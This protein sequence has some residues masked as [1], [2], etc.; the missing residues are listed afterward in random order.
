MSSWTFLLLELTSTLFL[1][2]FPS[3]DILV[4]TCAICKNQIMDL[5]APNVSLPLASR[6]WARSGR[7][8]PELTHFPFSRPRSRSYRHRV[9][10]QPGVGNKRGVHRRLGSV[11]RESVVPVLRESAREGGRRDDLVAREDREPQIHSLSSTGALWSGQGLLRWLVFLLLF[12]SLRPNGSSNSR[13]LVAFLTRYY[14]PLRFPPS[15]PQHAFHFHCIS[16]WLKTRQGWCLPSLH[17]LSTPP[18]P[19]LPLVSN[20]FPSAS[21]LA[22]LLT[23][24][25]PSSTVC[26]L[27]NRDWELQ[28]FVL[29]SL[30]F[31]PSLHPP[32]RLP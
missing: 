9:P 14:L 13:S 22:F 1:L 10:S 24:P 2:L 31:F 7:V 11:Q 21:W 15:R 25:P 30:T 4:D 16:R 6:E 28:R 20:P 23:F 19:P 5:C 27:D 3:T 18:P 17:F 12:P 8:E 26:P 29:S 32:P